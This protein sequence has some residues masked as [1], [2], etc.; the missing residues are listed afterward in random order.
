MKDVKKPY[1]LDKVMTTK[2]RST[3]ARLNYMASERAELQHSVKELCRD[4][5]APTDMSLQKLKR[6]GRYLKAMPRVKIRFDF[7]E[8]TRHIVTL[9]DNDWSGCHRTRTSTNGGCATICKHAIKTWSSTQGIFVST[10]GEAEYDGICKAGVGALGIRS[11]CNDF[12]FKQELMIDTDSTVAKGVSA[13]RHGQD[14]AHGHPVFVD[15][16]ARRAG[17]NSEFPRYLAGGTLSTLMTNYLDE[18]TILKHVAAMNMK[19]ESGRSSRD[20]SI[21][22]G[23]MRGSMGHGDVSAC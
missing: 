16:A 1:M 14:Q 9:S 22:A 13:R 7:Q 12:D 19:F 6:V 11:L 15:P 8:A 21:I 20:P 18:I 5:S 17:E 2:Y 10:S 23:T 3:T 4:M